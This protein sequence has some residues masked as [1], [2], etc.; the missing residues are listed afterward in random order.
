MRYI[1]GKKKENKNVN[2]SNTDFYLTPQWRKT[3]NAYIN[4][5]PLCEM[6]LKAGR[7]TPG[8]VVDH[9]TPIIDGGAKFDFS[10]LQTLCNDN[11]PHKCHRVKTL[12]DKQNRKI[13]RTKAAREKYMKSLEV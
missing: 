7:V 9:I 4:A 1:K 2:Y 11:S 10:N 13:N 3:R 5:N 6:C 12:L 8:E